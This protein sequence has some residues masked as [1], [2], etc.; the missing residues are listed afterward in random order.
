LRPLTHTIGYTMQGVLEV[1]IGSG[2]ED[3]VSAS[4][5]CLVGILPSISANG[6]LPGQLDS[7]WNPAARWVCLTGSAQIAIVAYRLAELLGKREY[8]IAADRLVDFLKAVQHTRTGVAGID[9]AIAG[10]YPITGG[11]M[12]FGYPNWATKYF[13]DAL[14]IQ[15]E[16]AGLA[17]SRN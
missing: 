11:Y 15:S 2:R 8:A 5:R 12:S 7:H 10:S 9:G 1:G 17:L 13:L 4:E 6:A 14:M 3:F 16:R